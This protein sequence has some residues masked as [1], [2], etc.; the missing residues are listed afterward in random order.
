MNTIEYNRDKF[1]SPIIEYWYKLGLTSY[2]G[3]G[4][5]SL[6]KSKHATMRSACEAVGLL[7]NFRRWEHLEH[8][9][10]AVWAFVISHDGKYP[11]R[12]CGVNTLPPK[13]QLSSCRKKNG[14]VCS[15]VCAH[16]WIRTNDPDHYTSIQ[17]KRRANNM[18][19]YGGPTPMSCPIIAKKQSTSL[20]KRYSIDG[21]TLIAKRTS[22]NLERHGTLSGWT[23]STV[24]LL[25]KHFMETL[26]VPSPLLLE[27][28]A[29]KRTA[30]V[31]AF[32]ADPK[33]RKRATAKARS[34]FAQRNGGIDHWTKLPEAA[35]RIANCASARGR[36]KTYSK[37]GIEWSLQ[38]SE[39]E[40]LDY[41]VDR[42]V[43]ARHVKF[44]PRVP[45]FE[46]CHRR[47]DRMYFPD[48]YIRSKNTIVEVKSPYTA[49]ERQGTWPML[50]AKARA[51]MNAGYRFLLIIISGKKSA[52]LFF[53]TDTSLR[54]VKSILRNA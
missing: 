7:K 5:N 49:F 14:T 35:T 24:R 30:G 36:L 17:S 8:L 54:N 16:S 19:V 20:K 41:L 10:P 47:R 9:L 31:K 11:C 3:R 38:G 6:T 34:T 51:V 37:Y 46:Y 13:D 23:D 45:R 2:P 12:I 21:Q 53:D 25:R 43:Q 40:A 42:G 1:P 28:S 26:G 4:N 39:P 52:H 33:N 48:F 18:L 44:G 29:A 50:R 15:K 22:T 27:S 32:Y